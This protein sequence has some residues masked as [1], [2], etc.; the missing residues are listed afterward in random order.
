MP[1]P[2]TMLVPGGLWGPLTGFYHFLTGYLFPLALWLEGREDARI[3]VADCGPLNPWFD[4][5]VPRESVELIS[6]GAMLREIARPEVDAVVLR[7]LDD[8]ELY[9]PEE[10]QR[11]RRLVVRRLG[12][13]D[14]GHPGHPPPLP[15]GRVLLLDRTFVDPYFLE[16]DIKG[17]RFSGSGPTRRTIPNI[18]LVEAAI[19]RDAEVVRDDLA[20]RSPSEQVSLVAGSRV[21]VAQHGAGL[22]NMLWLPPGSSVLEVLPPMHARLNASTFAMLARDLGHTYAVVHQDDLHAPVDPEAIAAEVRRIRQPGARTS[23]ARP[24]PITM[25]QDRAKQRRRRRVAAREPLLR[26]LAVP[27]R[28]LLAALGRRGAPTAAPPRWAAV[29]DGD[30]AAMGRLGPFLLGHL[31]PLLLALDGAPPSI[32][33]V[34]SCPPLDDWFEVLPPEHRIKVL[35]VGTVM[36]RYSTRREALRLLPRLEA[37]TSEG[38]EAMRRTRRAL[39][40]RLAP[41]GIRGT[42][43]SSLVTVV[44]GDEA[45]ALRHALSAQPALADVTVARIDPGTRPPGELVGTLSRTSVLVLAPDSDAG[46]M[47][48]L[49]E[50]AT[51][52]DGGTAGADVEAMALALGLRRHHVPSTSGPLDLSAVCALVRGALDERGRAPDAPDR[53]PVDDEG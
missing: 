42:A 26:L 33:T 32:V 53:G 10:L 24:H 7:D 41:A 44:G 20:A 30:P 23:P 48:L 34:R 5:V 31:G 8:P 43:S 45:E 36:L 38:I 51:V 25:R 50:G 12:L 52:I 17:S 39:H 46:V 19:A 2:A 47:L 6:P 49:A 14:V 3:I 1:A 15:E 40:A 9:V 27:L 13:P 37:S 18:R 11:F 4:L 22:T 29:P 35:D 21:L 16:H 28:P